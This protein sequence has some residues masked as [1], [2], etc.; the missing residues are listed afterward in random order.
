MLERAREVALLPDDLDPTLHL[1]GQ[2]A[3]HRAGVVK[4]YTGLREQGNPNSKAT[5]PIIAGARSTSQEIVGVKPA[6]PQT[7]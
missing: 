1:L 3:E 5:S 2:R 7:R 6:V 4:L